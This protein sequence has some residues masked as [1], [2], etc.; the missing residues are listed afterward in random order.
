MLEM[1]K[2]IS[3]LPKNPVFL[4]SILCF[5]VFLFLI[6]RNVGLY[7]SIFHDEY[8]YSAFS[9][10][11][12]L[13]ES[14][15]PGYLYLWIYSFTSHCGNNFL[16]CARGVNAL[17]FV[18]GAI[19][20]FLI[21][22]NIVSGLIA[23]LIAIFSI[24]GPFHIYTA[25]FMPESM[26]FFSF[27]FFT[28]KLMGLKADSRRR[29][30]ILTGFLLGCASLVKPHSLLLL[31]AIAAYSIY[32]ACE[33]RDCRIISSTKKPFL[34]LVAAAI[35]KFSIGFLFAGKSGV[36][37]FGSLYSELAGGAMQSLSVPRLFEY[38]FQNSLGHFMASA[39]LYGVPF[40]ITVLIVSDLIK[41]RNTA[42]TPLNRISVFTILVLLNLIFAT[43]VFT[44]LIANRDGEQFILHMRYYDF[45]LPLFYIIAGKAMITKQAR[46]HLFLYVLLALLIFIACHTVY[47]QA[48]PFI[49]YYL[50]SPDFYGIKY[51]TAVFLVFGVISIFALGVCFWRVEF[52]ARIYFCLVLPYFIVSSINMA[53][54]IRSWDVEPKACDRAGLF[55]RD[56]LS[57]NDHDKLVVV[58]P[59][60][61]FIYCAAFHID[62]PGVSLSLAP[63][64]Q[65]YDFS[66]LPFDKEWILFIGDQVLSRGIFSEIRP[67][68]GFTLARIA[69]PSYLI[70][71][72]KP[73]WPG[74]IGQKGLSYVEILGA[75]SV[76]DNVEIEFAEPLPERVEVTILA[77]P[78]GAAAG[79]AFIAK[80]GDMESSFML[81]DG[82]DEPVVLE[83]DNPT[84]SRMLSIQMPRSPSDESIGTGDD[85]KNPG[86]DLLEMKIKPMTSLSTSR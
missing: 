69:R 83:F 6:L 41:N 52:G 40:F 58:G 71:F 43:A 17:F 29:D 21:A 24:I 78:R 5:M 76:A 9:R 63:Q 80:I 33:K 8:T 59:H 38:V 48:Y 16:E 81:K 79:K 18:S 23:A 64:D 42:L 56:Y 57:G 77:R 65:P 66:K 2:A 75:R 32:I 82:V 86:L 37:I 30:W 61:K 34:F 36:T 54:L 55:A 26:Y 19:F 10:L 3:F 15:I 12:P 70:D 68:D 25:Y 84:R 4:L 51:D 60:H 50:H 13:S 7:P 72:S 11:F 35:A 45:A 20:I 14:P 73:A 44:A 49:I 31:P 39:L 67:M 74:I 53:G 27:W 47:L 85:G 62:S 22:R 28:W 1:K 46:P